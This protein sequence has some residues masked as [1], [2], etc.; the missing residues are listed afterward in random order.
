ML[1]IQQTGSKRAL[2]QNAPKNHHSMTHAR[3]DVT[4]NKHELCLYTLFLH[5]NEASN[6]RLVT[7]SYLKVFE[8]FEL[9]QEVIAELYVQLTPTELRFPSLF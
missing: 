4:T 9:V 2:R 6:T 1:Q 7:P 8:L 5:K 3:Q